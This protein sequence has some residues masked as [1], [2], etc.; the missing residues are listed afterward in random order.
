MDEQMQELKQK[1][2]EAEEKY[3]WA[4]EAGRRNQDDMKQI[5]RFSHLEDLTPEAVDAFIKKVILYG[6]K[7]VEIEWNFAE[8]ANAFLGETT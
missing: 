2:E 5:I 8:A 7:R 4:E 6:D 3:E 1:Q